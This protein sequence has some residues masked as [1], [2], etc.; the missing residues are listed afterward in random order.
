MATVSIGN[1]W[2]QCYSNSK[3]RHYWFN[4]T[5]N[6]KSWE[7]PSKAKLNDKIDN[8]NDISTTTKVG[9]IVDARAVVSLH[10]SKDS[11]GNVVEKGEWV[12]CFSKSNQRP[13]W[14]NKRTNERSWTVPSSSYNKNDDQLRKGSISSV[15][16]VAIE[17]QTD[18]RL[19]GSNESKIA[20]IVPF[21]DLHVEQ[22]R[23]KHL[24]TFI[25]TMLKF[26][27]PTGMHYHIYIIEQSN[28]KRK[29]NIGKLL[30]IGFD[31]ASKEGCNIFIFHDVDLLPSDELRPYYC[32]LPHTVPIH[33]AK[34]WGRYTK[35][36][37]Y[38]G[39]IV[40]FSEQMFRD[41]NGF[42][43]NFWG[44]L[45]EDHSDYYSYF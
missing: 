15:H 25:P 13:Y 34:V 29:F 21:R 17:A 43:N 38:L 37:K 12:Q 10:Q 40:S 3:Q 6:E 14:F 20:I 5:T 44:K 16:N 33:I 22:T 28:D 36:E 23:A 39:G 18:K 1:G 7:L 41:I 45:I 24:E 8:D 19:D 26:L 31:L 27:H 30:N 9:T 2:V 32:K 35:N 11:S 42:P 4:P